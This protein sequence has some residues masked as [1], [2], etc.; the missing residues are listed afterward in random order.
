MTPERSMHLTVIEGRC[1]GH[2][3]CESVAPDVFALDADGFVQVLHSRV[4]GDLLSQA[5]SGIRSCPVA[6]LTAV[7]A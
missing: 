1:D 6:A 3:Q 5:Q 7:D 2:G 4:S